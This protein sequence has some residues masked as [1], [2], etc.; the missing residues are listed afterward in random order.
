MPGL[1]LDIPRGVRGVRVL[2]ANPA[3][4]SPNFPL[5]ELVSF[6]EKAAANPEE[7][8]GFVCRLRYFSHDYGLFAIFRYARRTETSEGE[9]RSVWYFDQPQ[10]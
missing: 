6:L 2:E 4:T 3:I 9:Y 8:A 1:A 7:N 10:G 5:F